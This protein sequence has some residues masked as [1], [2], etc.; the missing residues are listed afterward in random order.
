MYDLIV[1]LVLLFLGFV[2]GQI[3]EKRHFRS[4]IRRERE[5][6]G[7]LAFTEPTTSGASSAA[8]AILSADASVPTSHSWN[9]HAEKQCCA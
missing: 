8:C 7:L 6:R 3:A 4:I 1:F 5:M 9:A 2:F